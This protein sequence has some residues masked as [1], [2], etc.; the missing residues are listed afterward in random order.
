MGGWCRVGVTVVVLEVVGSGG[1]GGGWNTIFG[2]AGLIHERQ[3]PPPLRDETCSNKLDS[4]LTLSSV[5]MQTLTPSLL[6]S[7][8]LSH[9]VHGSN[10][11]A[12]AEFLEDHPAVAAV[13]YPGE[14][15]NQT[16]RVG[17]SLSFLFL[18]LLLHPDVHC[19]F[20]LCLRKSNGWC[21][22]GVSCSRSTRDEKNPLHPPYHLSLSLPAFS[23]S[24]PFLFFSFLPTVNTTLHL[25]PPHLSTPPHIHLPH[26]RASRP[27]RPRHHGRSVPRVRRVRLRRDAVLPTQG[28]AQR[29]GGGGGEPKSISTGH[30]LGG[31]RVFGGAPAL[32]RAP[33]VQRHPRRP[34][35]PQRG[36]RARDRLDSRPRLRPRSGRQAALTRTC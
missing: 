21:L 26:T 24:L 17:L 29:C 20:L 35:P 7:L 34:A 11:L 36:S 10:A 12:V 22:A 31:N 23:I 27:P 28:G 25:S 6:L 16:A 18:C 8:T 2:A 5:C 33:R 15:H 4:H 9:K 13:H 14:Q 32:H 19:S 1:G 30:E 3:S